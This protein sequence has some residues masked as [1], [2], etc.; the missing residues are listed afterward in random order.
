MSTFKFEGNPKQGGLPRGCNLRI[1]ALPKRHLVFEGSV[2]EAAYIDLDP[3]KY[4]YSVVRKSAPPRIDDAIY[5]GEFL[6][7]LTEDAWKA[8]QHFAPRLFKNI[9]TSEGVRW[10]CLHPLCEYQASSPTAA[11]IHEMDH[12]GVTREDFLADPTGAAAK[13]AG[14]RSQEFSDQMR[15]AMKTAGRQMPNPLPV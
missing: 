8:L 1:E 11:L 10:R 9:H 6:H 2:S 14:R 12:F 5:T 4:V 7:E 3:G 15:A 13:A